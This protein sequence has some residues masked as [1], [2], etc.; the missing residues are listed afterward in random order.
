MV[1]LGS[2]GSKMTAYHWWQTTRNWVGKRL[3]TDSATL[4]NVK[5][6]IVTRTCPLSPARAGIRL[7]INSGKAARVQS[8]RKMTDECRIQFR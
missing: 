3:L 2:N 4:E 8:A 1:I 6:F 7:N 5:D